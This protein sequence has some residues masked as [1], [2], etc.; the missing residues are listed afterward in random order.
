MST[1]NPKTSRVV[2]AGLMVALG[3]MAPTAAAVAEQPVTPAPL[4]QPRSASHVYV[5]PS[6][7]GAPATYGTIQE[8]LNNVSE[9]G[10]IELASDIEMN[11]GLYIEKDVSIDLAGHSIVGPTNAAYSHAAIQVS[12]GHSLSIDG[13]GSITSRHEH[14]IIVIGSLALGDCTLD[15]KAE[16]TY[17]C[18]MVT[19]SA[20][21]ATVDGATIVN[22]NGPAVRLITPGCALTVSDGHLAGSSGFFDVSAAEGASIS[23]SGGTFAHP[24]R[25][26]RCASGYLPRMVTYDVPDDGYTVGTAIARPTAVDRTFDGTSQFGAEDGEGYV[27]S[28]SA[29]DAGTHTTTAKL[30]DGYAWESSSNNGPGSLP[31][32]D[33]GDDAESRR[34]TAPA[35]LKWTMS[36]R[37]LEP[38]MA[39]AP[40][41]TFD[42][43]AKKPLTISIGE[44]TLREGVDYQ[45]TYTN[46]VAAGTA[47]WKATGK[48]NTTGT[49]EGTFRIAPAD[50]AD[51]D[52]D[53]IADQTFTGSA[54]EPALAAALGN[55]KLEAGRDYTVSYSDNVNP[56]EAK[57]TITGIGSFTGTRELTFKIVDQPSTPTNDKVTPTKGQTTPSAKKAAST[58]RTGDPTETVGIVQLALAGLSALGLGARRR[59]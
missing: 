21:S 24:V 4:M 10:T 13:G 7:P 54:I 19:G 55:Y 45:V 16:G 43:S 38:E 26:D 11:Q 30:E 1:L 31:S 52:F 2:T 12:E 33:E 32:Q 29:V 3:V 25:A 46:N 40:D 44:T 9:G 14:T 51:V 17:P 56:G 48:D 8:A 22:K 57:V 6:A 41:Q 23:I 50:I 58:P 37:E 47:T 42:G 15:R 18:V 36:K 20:G 5:D 35:E 27:L 49:I 53:D 39:E 59:R 34:N 28:G